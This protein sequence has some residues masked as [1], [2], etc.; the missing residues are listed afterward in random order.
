[1]L[2]LIFL[3]LPA[4]AAV[5]EVA[6]GELTAA[7]AA[8]RAGDTLVLLPGVHAGP[9]TVDKP[10]TLRGRDGAVI[11]GGGTG[12]VVKVTAADAALRDLTI[13]NSGRSLEAMDSGVFLDKTADRAVVAGN[14]I[15]GSLFGV[16][17]W[18][19]DDALVTGNRI[20]GLTDLRVN[21][22]GNGVSLWNAPGSR[23]E[24]NLIRDGRDGIFTTTSKRNLFAGNRFE[25]VRFAVHYMY[26]NQSEVSGNV[27]IGND[28]G[29]ALMYSTGIRATGN[30]SRGDRDHGFML[31]FANSSEVVGNAVLGGGEKCV[32]IY[33]SNKSEFRRNWFEGCAIGVHFTAGSER[34]AFRANAFVGNETQVKYVGTRHLDWATGGVGNYWSDNVAFDL[35]GDGIADLPYRPNDLVDQVVWRVPAAKLLLNSPAVLLV[36]WA[37]SQFPALMP[38]GVVDTAPLMSP[39]EIAALPQEAR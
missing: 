2:A 27:S 21:E 24:D 28:V 19:P 3:A 1:V 17:V 16:Y 18:G 20:Q 36:R 4:R 39:P 13:R 23:V 38:G 7:L 37:Q 10:L 34:N 29:Y 11:D 8:A 6:P 15:E 33:N 31:N 12:N 35:D 22:R 32:F 30:V 5:I 9:V 26:T 25:G 14:L